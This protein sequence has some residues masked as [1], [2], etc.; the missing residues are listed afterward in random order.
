M[1]QSLLT[2]LSRTRW[3]FGFVLCLNWHLTAIAQSDL[4]PIEQPIGILNLSS[5]ENGLKELG[6]MFTL[7]GRSDMID[8]IN[9]Y[10]STDQIRNLE[11]IDRARSM[12]LMVFLGSRLPPDP[13][14]VAYF[15]I[16]DEAAFLANLRRAGAD[17]IEE[18][19]GMY[20]LGTS[21]EN[22]SQLRFRDGYA[23]IAAKPGSTFLDDFRTPDPAQLTKNISTRY[24][25]SLTLSLRSIPPLMKQVFAT[26][27]TQQSA[28]QLQQRDTESD[29]A[30]QARRAG[31]LSTLKWI[32]QCLRDGEEVVIGV[33]STEDGR[34]AV[35]EF[36]IDATENS[37][38]A[39]CLTGIAGAPSIF[40]PL[41]KEKHPLQIS[42]SWNADP[43]EKTAMLGF[44]EAIRLEL[45]HKLSGTGHSAVDRV[46]ETLQATVNAG[47]IDAL[48][49][50][51]PVG[52]K[53]FVLLAGV[54]VLGA[55]SLSGQLQELVRVISEKTSEV[56][57]E[58]HV[59]Q[60]EQTSFN[61]LRT[62]EEDRNAP[63]VF[64]GRPDIYWGV[65]DNILWLGVGGNQ[66]LS[67]FDSA[68]DSLT[69][70]RAAAGTVSSA[71]FQLI[72]RAV[73]WM[74]VTETES[75]GSRRRERRELLESSLKPED[76]ALRLEVRPSE[77]GVRVTF[78][79]DEG[80]VR[81]LG[82][83]LSEV[84]DRSQL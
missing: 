84:Y 26:F 65:G 77:S 21:K 31:G 57:A 83:T 82:T 4:R 14:P 76:D 46:V 1:Q 59:H 30:Y 38:F 40:T 45:Q 56:S 36:S 17:V 73:P 58:Y 2:L 27:F 11:G 47:H 37:E 71:P 20:L 42:M 15:P 3:A 78:R 68:I 16:S 61:R 81:L 72:F 50:F 22:G 29:A 9:S 25:L 75:M 64:G 55:E 28:A 53:E 60:H 39:K 6:Q 54:K 69:A 34:R 12:G 7:A 52:D 48:I 41:L 79:F 5:I 67:A 23:L 44:L 74:K 51:I 70:P 63:Q 35:F 43:R 33:D 10:L 18:A 80:F 62:K 32:E 49:Q 24:D 8:V 13:V 19:D 66:M